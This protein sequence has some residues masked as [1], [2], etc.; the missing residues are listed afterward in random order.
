M[1]HLRM[2]INKLN[3]LNCGS[4]N[5][6]QYTRTL[7]VQI[8]HGCKKT[9]EA[10]FLKAS[11]LITISP[12][13]FSFFQIAT[14]IFQD[15]DNIGQKTLLVRGNNLSC[16]VLVSLWLLNF[17]PKSMNCDTSLYVHTKL[18]RSFCFVFY[19]TDKN[20]IYVLQSL[21]NSFK[22]FVLFQKQPTTH[23]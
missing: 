11:P 15:A 22:G 3:S 5:T 1:C 2:Y 4:K 21:G 14:A 18:L 6:L 20:S 8:Y 9:K 23:H 17:C 10:A 12:Q 19:M 13:Y 7:H 16:L